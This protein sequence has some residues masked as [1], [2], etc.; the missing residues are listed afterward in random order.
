MQDTRT[1]K[2]WNPIFFSEYE[3][4]LLDLV[5]GTGTKWGGGSIDGSEAVS[6]RNIHSS[7]SA[8]VLHL[9]LHG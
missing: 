8:L 3:M 6:V 5:F 2:L 9:K 1:N 4:K 7:N